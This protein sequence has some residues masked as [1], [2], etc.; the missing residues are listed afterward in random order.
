L[1]RSVQVLT[2]NLKREGFPEGSQAR[3][4]SWACSMPVLP[5]TV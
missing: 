3:S 2:R 4:R 1:Y 5:L